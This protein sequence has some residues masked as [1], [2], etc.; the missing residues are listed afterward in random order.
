M[1]F[2]RDMMKEKN[3]GRKRFDERQTFWQAE[4]EERDLLDVPPQTPHSK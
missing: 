4:D 2:E 3:F 1:N